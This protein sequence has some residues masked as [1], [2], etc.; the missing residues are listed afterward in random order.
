MRLVPNLYGGLL[1]TVAI[2]VGYSFT[3]PTLAVPTCYMSQEGEVIDLSHLCGAAEEAPEEEIPFVE[4]IPGM[5]DFM[6]GIELHGNGNSRAALRSLNR[7]IEANPEEIGY[8]LM[9]SLIHSENGN[10]TRRAYRDF[11]AL[12]QI[13]QRQHQN[14]PNAMSDETLRQL[15]FPDDESRQ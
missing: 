6:R 14:D 15:F 13:H 5:E 1:L 10:F 9:R 8:Y 12:R 3:M 11:E 4:P 7:A 2:S